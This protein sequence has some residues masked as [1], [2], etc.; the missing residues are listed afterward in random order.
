MEREGLPFPDGDSPEDPGHDAVPPHADAEGHAPADAGPVAGTPSPREDAPDQRPGESA[1]AFRRRAEEAERRAEAAEEQNRRFYAEQAQRHQH[2]AMQRENALRQYEANFRQQVRNGDLTPAQ[3]DEQWAL[4]SAAKD[5]LRA[6]AERRAAQVEQHVS[7]QAFKDHLAEK[8]A[9]SAAERKKLDAYRPADPNDYEPY[10]MELVERRSELAA[11]RAD[12][13]RLKRDRE[14]DEY[15]ASGAHRLPGTSRGP[16]GRLVAP[17]GPLDS[18]Q[19]AEDFY[20]S[21]PRR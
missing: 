16:G 11:V 9:L 14:A 3:I 15:A 13:E 2:D 4:I 8:H 7:V 12:I 10:A 20:L 5:E 21:I 17:T 18:M 19:A 6:N 1:E